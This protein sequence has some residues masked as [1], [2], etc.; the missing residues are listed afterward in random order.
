MLQRVLIAALLVCPLMAQSDRGT[1]TGRVLDPAAA[2]V[3][4]ARVEAIN[5]GT[6]VKYTAVSS[7]A[8]MYSVQQVPAG[9]YDVSVE[10]AGFSRYL[11]RDVEINVAQTVTLNVTL[12]VGAVDQTVE[13]TAAAP[14]LE[15]NTSDVG[16]V[17]NRAMVM[18]LP[19]SV[20]GN[21]RNPESFIFLA[22][23]VTGDTTNTQINGSQSRAKEVLVDGVGS[24]SPES[25]GVL[26]TYPFGGGHRG[27]Q[28]AE[29][30]LQRRVRPH[31]R[32]LRD[33]HHEIRHQRAA[34]LR[35]RLPAQRR[36]GCARVLCPA[37]RP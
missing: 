8:G 32:R 36:L 21:M 35:I 2:L 33:L 28:A 16:T 1:I 6:Q 24:T 37:R 7:E 26:F 12:T 9:R 27:V 34:R 30:Q 10:A 31:R 18:D 23:G 29:Q 14:A 22:P 3:P 4:N 17:V 15:T 13:V 19:L 11:R 25:G 20:S 5:Q